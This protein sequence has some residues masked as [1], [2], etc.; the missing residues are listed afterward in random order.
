MEWITE[1]IPEEVYFNH[2]CT[3]IEINYNSEML[4][5]ERGKSLASFTNGSNTEFLH[6]IVRDGPDDEIC[7]AR[8]LWGTLN[9]PI[10]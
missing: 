9:T 10:S 6:K 2:D 7:R 4:S 5:G 8:T 1:S 3:L